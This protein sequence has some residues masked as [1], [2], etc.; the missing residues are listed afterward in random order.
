MPFAIF[1][2]KERQK[3]KI[4][5]NNKPMETEAANLLLLA[6]ELALPQ[7]GV[8]MALNNRM[9]PRADW[10]TTPLAEGASIVII[11]AACGG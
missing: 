4:S 6:E 3:M 5:V 8:A 2:L 9:I 11:Q 7:R 1:P 10:G